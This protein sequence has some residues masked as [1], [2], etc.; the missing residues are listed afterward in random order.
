MSGPDGDALVVVGAGQAGAELAFS[1]RQLGFPGPITLVGDEPHHPY[2]RPPLSKSLL[3]SDDLAGDPWVRGEQAYRSAGITVLTGARVSR[4]DRSRQVV[5]LLDGRELRYAHLGLTTGGRPR[6]LA[7]GPGIDAYALHTLDDARRLRSALRPELRLLVVGG[8]FLGLEVAAA[9]TTRGVRVV[10]VEARPRLLERTCAAPVAEF[11]LAAHRS[12]GVDVRTGVAVAGARRTGTGVAV[13]LTD[14]STCEVDAVVAGIGQVPDDGLARDA[15]LV[16]DDGI[17]VDQHARTSDPRI[18][19]AGDC[20]RQRHGHLGVEVRLESQQNATDQARIAARSV[21][22]AEHPASSVPWF[23]SD[24]YTHKLQM[25]GVA[26]P[27][28]RV[29][30]RGTPAGGGLT[31]LTLRGDRLTSV[32]SVDRPRD[33]LAGRTLLSRNALLRPGHELAGTTPLTELVRS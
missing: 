14:G 16:V 18:V 28:D 12:R 10:L 22:G 26:G 2:Q 9:A 20:T 19:A 4:V 5:E 30:R 6:R 11:L 21:C 8:G 23:W 32:Q 25:A 31:V 33:F 1:A 13:S 3:H 15:G 29:V 7:L 27:G 24:Q 17:V